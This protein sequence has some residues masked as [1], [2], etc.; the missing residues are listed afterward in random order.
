MASI[1]ETLESLAANTPEPQWVDATILYTVVTEA[2]ILKSGRLMLQLCEQ[3]TESETTWCLSLTVKQSGSRYQ[4]VEI[5]INGAD[6][7]LDFERIEGAAR[8]LESVLAFEVDES[9]KFNVNSGE[10]IK[11]NGIPEE[12]EDKPAHPVAFPPKTNESK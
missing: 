2:N 11:W 9:I 8:A 3:L 6:P 7:E 1:E 5:S 10:V 4:K 12:V